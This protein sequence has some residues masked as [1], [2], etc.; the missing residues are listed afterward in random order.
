[1]IYRHLQTLKLPVVTQRQQP[2]AW[3]HSFLFFP[4]QGSALELGG[5]TSVVL[6]TSVVG[7]AVAA[8][9]DPALGSEGGGDC[10]HEVRATRTIVTDSN[11]ILFMRVGLQRQ[12]TDRTTKLIYQ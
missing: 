9:V 10:E 5:A 12:I 6:L 3:S 8:G 11:S 4:A 2:P 7:D 1:M